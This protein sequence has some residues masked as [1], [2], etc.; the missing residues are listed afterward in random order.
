MLELHAARG[1]VLTKSSF[2]DHAE[3]VQELTVNKFALVTGASRGIGREIA[4]QLAA[5]GVFVVINYSRS[6]EEAEHVA[7]GICRAGGRAV[8]LCADVS[9]EEQVRKMFADIADISPHLDFLVNNAGIDNTRPIESYEV[10]AWRRIIDVNLTGKFLVL[11]HAIPC[12]R[13]A[14][15]AAVVN[16][17]SRLAWKPLEAASAYCCAATAVV[18]MTKCAALE[19]AAYKIRV[20]AVCPGFTRTALTEALYAEEALWTQAADANPLQRV[21]RPADA[22][23]AT[24]YLLSDEAE[25]VNGTHLIVDGGSLL[26]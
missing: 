9:D 3:H 2:A 4:E 6:R 13:K 18:M 7:A 24:L 21:G 8:A 22:A 15:K 11:K 5:R 23:K 20:N 26:T 1:D 19:L 10:A 25:Y 16:I 17:A 12:L 14:P